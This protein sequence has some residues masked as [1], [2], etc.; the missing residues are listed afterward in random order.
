MALLG[1]THD[2]FGQTWHLPCDDDRITYRRF[3]ELAAEVF[4]TKARHRVV[5]RW[6]LALAGLVNAQAR[7]AAE[8]LPRY[9]KDN[10]FVSEKFKARFPDFTVTTFRQGLSAIAAEVRGSTPS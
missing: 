3:I 7:D 2:A 9:E 4:G 5:E 8:L 1:N 6:Q 10:L